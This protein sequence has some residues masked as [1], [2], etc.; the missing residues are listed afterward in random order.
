MILN[1]RQTALLD[2]VRSQGFASIDALARKFGVTLQTVRRDVNLLAE[3]GMLTRFHGGVRMENSTT[4]NIAYRQRQ[5]LNAEGK[6]RIGRAVAAAVP[7]G[8]SLILNIGTT[9][10]EIAR[11]LIHHRGLR[12]ITNNLHVANILADNPDCEVIVAG[13]VLRSRDRGI[14]GEATVE[15]IRQFKVD[16][17]LIGISGIE[18]DGTLRDFDFREVKVA[19][20]I[21]EHSREIWLAADASKFNRQAMVELAPLSSVDRL[22][23]DEPLREPFVQMLGDSGVNCVVADPE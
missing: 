6:A 1:P 7:D 11:A 22:F 17:G 18:A 4:E 12:V 23:T 10:E 5:L 3:N 9:V 2:E 14:I 19:R 21:M 20:T 16:I 8:C 13:G 15:F